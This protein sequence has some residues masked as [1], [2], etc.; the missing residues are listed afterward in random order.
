VQRVARVPLREVEL[1]PVKIAATEAPGGTLVL[2]SELPL[3]PYEANLGAL[4]RR[5]AAAVPERPFLAERDHDQTRWRH[6]SYG[7]AAAH[8]EALGQALLDR[9]LGPER[10]LLILSGNSLD[11]AML[12]LAAL[13][14]GVPVVPVS[15]A[16][17]TLSRD[18]GTLRAIAR[19]VRPGL[20]FAADGEAFAAA[21]ASLPGPPAEVVVRRG[22]PGLRA[23]SLAT[24]LATTPGAAVQEAAKRVGPDSVAKILFTSGSTGEPK[25]VVTT[26]RM[27]CANQ[28]MLAQV[29]PFTATTPPVLL[30][31]MPWNHCFGGNH[32]FNL[33]LRCGG[34]LY[35]DGGRPVPG[36]IEQTVRNLAEVAPTIYLNV[37]A[38]YNALLPY[39]E[40][41]RGLAARFFDRLQLVFYAGAALPQDLWERLEALSVKTTGQRVAM[42]ASWGSTETAPLATAAHF[43]LERAGNIGVPVPGVELK[44]VA[45]GAKRELRVSGPNVFP[46]YLGRPDLTAAAFDEDGFYRIGD[47]GLLV[48]RHDPG[49]G[50]L[51]DGR[52]AEDFKLTTGTW[53]PCGKVRV[54]ALAAASPL[55]RDAVVA[56][57]DRASVGLLVWLNPPAVSRLAGV[58]AD[59]PAA[60]ARAPAVRDGIRAGIAAHNAAQTGSA[61][62]VRRVLVMT[63]PPSMDA[64]EITDKGYVNQRATLDRRQDL[65]E[66]LFAFPPDPDVIVVDG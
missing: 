56:G 3:E 15:V 8:A 14:V 49:K 19:L 11:H 41:D 52:I 65:V 30:D 54:A 2:R 31:W 25:G 18:F 64:G 16:Y 38:G 58:P 39:L 17:S 22:A 37:P 51:F 1:G 12:M 10:P 62:V 60:A 40:R 9:G 36:L 55:L 59:D 7:E 43:P 44:L 5:S 61:T 6:L 63:E 66:R 53:V 26:H 13:L 21:I 46:G 50:L 29:W 4:L 32:D 24:L 35:I 33:V 48:D 23:T 34:T 28:Q 42:T 47:A 57:A 27:L 20:V 45:S